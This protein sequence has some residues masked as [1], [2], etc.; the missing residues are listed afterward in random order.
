MVDH[1]TTNRRKYMLSPVIVKGYLVL[2][3]RF[4]A[5]KKA[6]VTRLA[7]GVLFLRPG[8]LYYLK[9]NFPDEIL[10]PLLDAYRKEDQAVM[11]GAVYP[12]QNLPEDRRREIFVRLRRAAEEHGIRLDIC[13]CKNADVVSGSCNIAGT[14]PGPGRVASRVRPTL[15]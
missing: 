3:A 7:A 15:A 8:I 13:A 14:W 9:K 4:S 12:I 11:R 6:G 1:S 2:S 10:A 5:L